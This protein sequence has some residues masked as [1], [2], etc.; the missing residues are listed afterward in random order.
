LRES[1]QAQPVRSAAVGL[2]LLPG[3]GASVRPR[4]RSG[5]R[6]GAEGHAD[7]E[8]SLLAV[9]APRRRAGIPAAARGIGGRAGGA[10]AAQARILVRF[11]AAAAVLHQSPG[12]ARPLRRGP[13]QSGNIVRA[14]RAAARPPRTGTTARSL[15]L[16]YL[17]LQLFGAEPPWRRQSKTT[18]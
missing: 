10:A 12:A 13:A 18:R 17:D 8:L 3:A 5:R 4:V 11:R 6:M 15:V 1:H 7:S 14:G 2:L 16:T 9:R